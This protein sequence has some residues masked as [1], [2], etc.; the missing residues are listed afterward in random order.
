MHLPNRKILIVGSAALCTAV[1]LVCLGV[2]WLS[3]LGG[4]NAPE[5]QAQATLR[6]R[7]QDGHTGADL[8]GAEVV[9]AETGEH[10]HTDEQGYTPDIPVP[11]LRDT[12]YDQLHPQEWGEISVLAYCEGYEDYALFHLQVE[13]GQ[14]RTDPVVMMF[15]R[16]QLYSQPFALVEGPK[17]EWVQELLDRFRPR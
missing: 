13:P 4:L 3:P 2:A 12:R 7:V 10:Y 14:A 5:A 6:I 15:E 8:P 17:A 11:I 16:D 9:I 1:I